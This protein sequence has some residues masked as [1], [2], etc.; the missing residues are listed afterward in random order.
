MRTQGSNKMSEKSRLIQAH[1]DD[2]LT[3]REI[4][5]RLHV[6]VSSVSRMIQRYNLNLR[7]SYP[8]KPLDETISDL[9]AKYNLKIP[10]DLESIALGLKL[11]IKPLEFDKDLSG[12]LVKHT[13]YVNQDMHLNRQRFTIAHELGH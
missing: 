9:I 11:K 3:M 1:L 6:N 12:M 2:G 8:K 7:P 13:I 5:R 4:A 10:V